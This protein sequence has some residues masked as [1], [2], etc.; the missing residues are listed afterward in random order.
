M[1][2]EQVQVMAALAGSSSQE[3]L[4]VCSNLTGK[5]GKTSVMFV[6]VR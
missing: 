1:K 5:V 6:L 2:M 4:R 3:E